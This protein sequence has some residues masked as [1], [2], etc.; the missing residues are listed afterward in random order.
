MLCKSPEAEARVT[1]IT[2]A[3]PL[4][5][6]PIKSSFEALPSEAFHTWE[7]SRTQNISHRGVYFRNEMPLVTSWHKLPKRSESGTWASGTRFHREMSSLWL[8]KQGALF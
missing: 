2:V 4:D 5:T 8:Y 3:Q 7:K 1:V 6:T